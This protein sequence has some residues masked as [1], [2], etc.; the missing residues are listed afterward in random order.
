M[1]ARA[2]SPWSND[3]SDDDAAWA[4]YIQSTGIPVFNTMSG[5]LALAMSPDAF[6]T[7]VSLVVPARGD[8]G[9]REEGRINQ[10]GRLVLRGVRGLQAARPGLKQGGPA[11]EGQGPVLYLGPF[12]GPQLHGPVPCRQG[13]RRRQPV[14]RRR[15]HPTTLRVVASCAQ[16]GTSRTWFRRAAPSRHRSRGAGHGRHDRRRVDRPVLRHGQPGDPDH[17]GRV[18]PVR[19]GTHHVSRNYSDVAVWQWATG[20]LIAAAAKAGDVGTTKP[21]SAAA[22]L[23]G[24]YALHSTNLDGLTPTLTFVKGQPH[25]NKCWFYAALQNGKFATPYGLTPTCAP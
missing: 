25:F 12:R 2:S 4:S 18:Q 19:A 10:A 7:L 9:G 22:L 5:S 23:S 24:V 14:R 20:M 8:S 1:S 15:S 3:D 11:G 13:G 21:L 17:D 16:Q 6:S